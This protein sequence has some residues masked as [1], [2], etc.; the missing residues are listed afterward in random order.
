MQSSF[1]RPHAMGSFCKRLSMTGAIR[2][3][4]VPHTVRW[5]GAIDRE[6][7]VTVLL[8]TTARPFVTLLYA[9][10]LGPRVRTGR[11]TLLRFLMAAPPSIKNRDGSNVRSNTP[12]RNCV[13]R[14]S[15]PIWTPPL[16]KPPSLWRP[17]RL[18][19]YIRPLTVA[20]D[21]CWAMMGYSR[22][23]S[24]LFRRAFRTWMLEGFTNAGSTGLPSFGV[25]SQSWL[26]DVLS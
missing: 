3:F 26:R 1:P 13:P 18:H 7:T 5:L 8:S 24:Q 12:R 17:C 9:H 14:S 23:G 22:F 4:H 11:T 6:F 16:C 25:A 19:T 20:S 2:D 15:I 21:R 10:R